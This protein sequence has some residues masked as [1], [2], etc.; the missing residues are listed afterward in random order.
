[1]GSPCNDLPRSSCLARGPAPAPQITTPFLREPRRFLPGLQHIF[2]GPGTA[3]LQELPPER[4]AELATRFTCD[5]PPA[6]PI[7]ADGI[8]G[9][10]REHGLAVGQALKLNGQPP[11]I[12]KKRQRLNENQP[13]CP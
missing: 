2:T 3:K 11:Q 6:L 12:T 8:A 13:A 7:P 10:D 4:P 5:L 9:A 1:M